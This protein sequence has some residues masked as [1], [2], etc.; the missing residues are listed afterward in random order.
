MQSIVYDN[1]K[2]IAKVQALIRGHL[3]KKR[4]KEKMDHREAYKRETKYFTRE[5]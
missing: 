5:E 3:A 4:L 1:I 2:S